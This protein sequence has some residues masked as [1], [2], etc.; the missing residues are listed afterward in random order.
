M[1]RWR[2]DSHCLCWGHGPLLSTDLLALWK[3]GLPYPPNSLL[4]V[5]LDL[6]FICSVLSDEHFLCAKSCVRCRGYS[7][8]GDKGP[9]RPEFT[10]LL[11][12]DDQQAK[13]KQRLFYFLKFIYLFYLF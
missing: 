10:I 7:Y 8:Q 2:C 9:S 5:G 3:A 13:R 4:Q 12:R 11:R 1:R 6:S